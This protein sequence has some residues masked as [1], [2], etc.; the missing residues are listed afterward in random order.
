LYRNINTLAWDGVPSTRTVIFQQAD[1][2][3]K[4]GSGYFDDL[5]KAKSV[6]VTIHQEQGLFN[7]VWFCTSFLICRWMLFALNMVL[8]LYGLSVFYES[9]KGGEILLDF[10]T[11]AFAMGMIGTVETAIHI[12]LP[13]S[14]TPTLFLDLTKN[15]MFDLAFFL[16]FLIWGG[17]LAQIQAQKPSIFFAAV[18]YVEILATLLMFGFRIAY[19]CGWKAPSTWL[20]MPY[21]KFGLDLICSSLFTFYGAGYAW[22]RW[23]GLVVSKSSHEALSK[24]AILSAVGGT[25]FF[26]RAVYQFLHQ[27]VRL[28]P[29]VLTPILKHET[30]GVAAVLLAVDLWIFCTAQ[31]TALILVYSVRLPRNGATPAVIVD[32]SDV[33]VSKVGHKWRAKAIK[34]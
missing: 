22:K 28:Y 10:R 3:K 8:L 29:S 13:A 21:C 23:R 7:Q 6:M 16:V 9:C 34:V 4:G 26:I 27:H 15:L 31:G 20:W 19:Y 32:V 18:V 17:V 11:A 25:V 1:L 5:I 12:A 30:S 33:V 2:D 14:T 24:L